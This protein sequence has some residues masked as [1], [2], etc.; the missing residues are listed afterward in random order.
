MDLSKL[1]DTLTGLTRSPQAR[2]EIGGFRA[3]LA[4]ADAA[5]EASRAQFEAQWRIPPQGD[6]SLEECQAYD[7]AREAD[8]GTWLARE[9]AWFDLDAQ[10]HPGLYPETEPEADLDASA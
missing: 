7:Q 5:R 3:R 10:L 1:R 4:A 9:E 8:F 2:A 6:A